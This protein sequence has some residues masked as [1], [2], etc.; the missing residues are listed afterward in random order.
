MAEPVP[1]PAGSIQGVLQNL[2]S[3]CGQPLA[4]V[5][6]TALERLSEFYRRKQFDM[7]WTSYTQI[8]ALLVQIEALVDD[9]LEPAAYHPE[10][11]RRAMLTATRDPLHREC[12]DVLASHAYLSALGHLAQGRLPQDRI[13][14]V[15]HRPDAAATPKAEA[16][17]M[18]IASE[19]LEHLEHTFNKARP[20]L[21]QYNNLRKAYARL[22]DQP[23]PEWQPIPT[24]QTL[25]PGMSDPRV[26]L[27][28]QRLSADGYLLATA[29]APGAD[30]RY[31]DQ[32]VDALKA[33][34]RR[35]ALQDDGILGA[36]TLTE[37][38]ATPA[39]RLNQLRVNLERFRWLSADI[40]PRSLLVDIAGGRVIYFRDSSPQWEARIQVGRDT[41]QTPS[42]KS[43]VTR[44]TLNPTWTVPPTILREDKLPQIRENPS[45]LAQH[46]M[47]VLDY[48][49]RVLDPATIDWSN[50]GRILL[51]QAAG[52]DNPL[53]RVVIRFA[54]PYSIYLHDTPSQGLFARSQRAFSSGCVRVESVMQL[55]D[56][57]LSEA[58][59]ERVAQ[60]LDTGLTYEYRPTEPT[61]ILL[62]YWTAEAD[63]N[64]LPRYRPD[65]YRRDQKLLAALQA[66]DRGLVPPAINPH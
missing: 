25:R 55:V 65:V 52:P 56:L 48:E 4:D 32:L 61:P 46:N 28:R 9:G 27:L 64:G 19:G 6:T 2:P 8:D 11:I 39:N 66:A 47:Q 37:L 13:E 31:S 16:H 60:L 17:L 43:I 5:D 12:S 36:D 57:L 62:A 30:D 59:R 33:F 23:E 10:A 14:P 18:S 41:R 26:P 7:L 58:E 29:G 38:N 21:E 34:Q 54:N 50:P 40:E 1:E 44:I 51:R 53:G 20:S 49:G 35:H 22:R 24:G 15:W 42:I 63:S 3:A 45:Y